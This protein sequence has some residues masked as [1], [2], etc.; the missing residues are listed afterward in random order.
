LK[1]FLST[2]KMISRST[3]VFVLLMIFIANFTH[4]SE[5]R[6]L[7]E[8]NNLG[9][10]LLPWP[11]FCPPG[12]AHAPPPPG[13][14]APS[15]FEESKFRLGLV[16]LFLEASLLSKTI[17]KTHSTAAAA[18]TTTIINA[19]TSCCSIFKHFWIS[20]N[21]LSYKLISPVSIITLTCFIDVNRYIDQSNVA[22]QSMR[23]KR[24]KN[25]REESLVL[26]FFR[27]CMNF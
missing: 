22:G 10:L 4:K 2:C 23:N 24:K 25:I 13:G 7:Q 19:T 8:P 17:S 9:A 3:F 16:F 5:A 11:H 18:S 1:S 20:L 15:N 26:F 12:W 27:C 6:Q 21:E 14:A